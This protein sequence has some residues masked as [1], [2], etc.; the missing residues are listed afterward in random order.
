MQIFKI[1][2]PCLLDTME[3][4]TE[5]S[6]KI[7][8][9]I[10]AKLVE[11]GAYVDEELPDYIMVMVANKKSQSQM[12][13]DLGLF[14]GTNTEKFT[15]WL[16][17]LIA[18]LQSITAESLQDKSATPSKPDLPVE[19]VSKFSDLSLNIKNHR[20]ESTGEDISTQEKHIV[21]DVRVPKESIRRKS[22]S[23]KVGL[24]VDEIA[25]VTQQ[26]TLSSKEHLS[27][28]EKA[29]VFS[30][31][32]SLVVKDS[33]P[34]EIPKSAIVSTTQITPGTLEVDETLTSSKLFKLGNIP[35]VEEDDFSEL[36][37]TENDE[38]TEELEQDVVLATDKKNDTRITLSPSRD[39]VNLKERQETEVCLTPAVAATRLLQTSHSSIPNL[40][41]KAVTTPIK[42]SPVQGTNAKLAVPHVTDLWTRKKRVPVSVIGSVT[43]NIDDEDEAYDPYNPAVGSVASVVKVTARKSSVPPKLQANK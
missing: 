34:L 40:I 7:R 20:S 41:P 28:K 5:I 18:K 11:L 27:D 1:N 42:S 12:T 24:I 14:L 30:K 17:G 39:T 6:Q 2:F 4:G 8:S 23:E 10:K 16:H 3:I 13:E 36:L 21:T 32:K 15:L 26:E 29:D 35:I 43:K 33:T 31:K 22:D 9:A 19:K 38:L 37:L 25:K